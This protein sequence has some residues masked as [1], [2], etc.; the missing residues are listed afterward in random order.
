[1]LPLGFGPHAGPGHRDGGAVLVHVAAVEPADLAAT[2]TD[3]HLVARRFQVGRVDEIDAVAPDH[4][5]RLVAVAL[6]G[7]RPHPDEVAAAAC[8]QDQVPRGLEN[9]PVYRPL[10][11]G[12]LPGFLPAPIPR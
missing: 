1:M 11:V 3:P 8:P 9:P 6:L 5:R 12:A 7:A 2:P 10:T 4:L